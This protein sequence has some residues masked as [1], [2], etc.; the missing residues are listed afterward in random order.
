MMRSVWLQRLVRDFCPPQAGTNWTFPSWMERE[1]E[2]LASGA[3]K[4]AAPIAGRAIFGSRPE[5]DA[6]GFASRV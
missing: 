5:S 2:K 1:Q 6:Q 3:K 4:F